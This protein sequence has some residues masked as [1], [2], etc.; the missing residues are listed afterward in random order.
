MSADR[1]PLLRRAAR[2]TSS[3]TSACRRSP[4]PTSPPEQRQRDGAVLP[5]ARAASARSASSCSSRSSRRPSRSSRDYAYFS[6]YSTSWLEHAA[7]YAE[8]MIER[9]GL[10]RARARSSRSPATTATCCSTSRERGIPVL[11]IEP[12]ANVAE[13]ARE[14]RAS[15]RWCEFFGVETAPRAR[16]RRAA[17]PICCSATTCSPTCPTST[18]SSRGMKILLKPER[19]DHDGVPAPA[20]ADR[21]ATSSTRS[22]TSTSPTSRF[23]TVE[24]VFARARPARCST[25][26]SCR[27]TAA[28]CGSTRCHA[29]DA[30]QA[31]DRRAPRELLRA[32]A[33]RGLRRRS[34]PTSAS[35][36]SVTRDKR[37]LLDFL[38][39]AQATQGKRD[40]R[41]RRA[42]QGQHAAQL[43]RHRR[44][45][46]R[47]HR[48]TCSPHK[49]GHFLPGTP[50]PD[51]R[52]GAR[53][54]E[55]RPDFVLILPWNLKDEII[56]Q[57]AL[58]PR[59][60]RAL[61]RARRPSS[62]LLRVRFVADA[63]ARARA[64]IE[65]ERARATSAASSRAPSTREEF[66]RAR[67][68]PGG[69]PVQRLRSTR[70]R[71]TLRGHALPGRRRTARPSSCA[72]CAGAIFDVA[73]D[74]R[75]GLADLLR[76]GSASS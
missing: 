24:R 32:R 16:G 43:L 9:F 18:T 46:H 76:A 15:R 44:R 53:S 47:L 58:H 39:D 7:R 13:V 51:P 40:R 3:P 8:Q 69:R 38:I 55:T 66:A 12:A 34:R 23:S 48:A 30:A 29:D 10:G 70:A 33:R 2:A 41:L 62:Q 49:Q 26:R 17:A 37:E 54:R 52:A 75:P 31:A 63:A 68:R 19:R 27:R 28:R 20:A 71:G 59:V 6:S 56:E 74:L 35:A 45:L 36:S 25:S 50:H 11:G 4:T 22:T 72:A 21:G 67:P 42:G 5:A 57:L 1:L 73:V 61:R 65:L 64:S 60:G 14:R